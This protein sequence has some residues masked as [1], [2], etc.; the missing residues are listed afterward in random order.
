MV[1]VIQNT[2]FK[3]N[4]IG[5]NSFGIGGVNAHALL[6]KNDKD[7]DPDC[8]KL[9]SQIPRLVNV[10]GRTEDAIKHI[11]DF[12][13]KNPKRITRDFLALLGE[14]MKTQPLRGSSGFPWRGYMLMTEKG[15]K[16]DEIYEYEY[17]KTIVPAQRSE[18]IWIMFSGMGSQ[19]PSMAKSLMTIPTFAKSISRAAN[20]LKP[21]NI[22][23]YDLLLSPD[24]ELLKKNT[25]NPFVAITSMQV[26]LFDLIKELNI[27]ID[28][29]VGHSFGEV[30]CAY[31][32]GCLTLEQSVLTAYWRGKI[33]E[34][35]RLPKGMLAAV[36]LSWEEAIKKCP[37]G[38][39]AACHNGSDSV[40]ISGLYEPMVKFVEELKKENIFVRPVAGGDYPYHSPFMKAVEAKLLEQL[41]AVIKTPKPRSPKWL[42]TSWPEEDWEQPDAKYASGKYFVNNLVTPVLF[43]EAMKKAMNMKHA[44]AV[45]EVA[46]HA[47]FESIFKRCFSTLNYVGLMKRGETDNL[48]YFLQAIGKIYTLGLNPDIENLYPKVQWPVARGTQSVGSLIKWDHDRSYM[49]KKYPEFHNFATASDFVMKFAFSDFDWMFLKDHC[50]DGRCLFPATGYI[51]IVWRRMAAMKGQPWNKTPVVFENVRFH[52][53]TLLSEGSEVKFVI[54][55]LEGTGDFTVSE[56]N[57]VAATGRVFI[58]DENETLEL[59]YKLEEDDDEEDKDIPEDDRLHE[60]LENKDIY[61]ELRIRGYDYGPK[62][63][64]LV[65]ARGDGRVGKCKWTGQFIS[66]FDSMM[67]LALVA[68]PIRALFVPVGFQQ[69][70]I[71]PNLLF[72]TIRALQKEQLELARQAE[73]EA[74]RLQEEAEQKE[75]EKRKD[76]RKAIDEVDN[77][78][79]FKMGHFME[80]LRPDLDKKDAN[81]LMQESVVSTIKTGEENMAAELLGTG[82]NFREDDDEED[83]ESKQTVILPVKFDIDLR[84]IVTKGLEVKG[85]IP[86]NIPRR[87]N[88]QGLTLEQYE[89]VPHSENEAIDQRFKNELVEYISVC[90]TLMSKFLKATDKDMGSLQLNGYKL[91]DEEL[92]KQYLERPIPNE[93]HVLMNLLK[94]LIALKYDENGNII[95][96]KIDNLD[97]QIREITSKKEFDLSNDLIVTAACNERLL[98]STLDIITENGRDKS[99]R[100]MELSSKGSIAPSLIHLLKSIQ[101]GLID[102]DCVV[103]TPNPNELSDSV[104]A[105]GYRTAEWDTSNHQFLKDTNNMELIL[106]RPSAELIDSWNVQEQTELLSN[107]LKV[108]GFLILSYRCKITPPEKTLKELLPINVLNEKTVNQFITAASAQNLQLIGTKS[109]SLTSTMLVFRKVKSSFYIKKPTVIN[110]ENCKMEEWVETVKDALSDFKMDAENSPSIWLIAKDHPNGIVGMTNCLRLEPGGQGFRCIYD[111]DNKLPPVNFEKSPYKELLQLD[112]ATNVYQ[113]G[114]WGT[115]KHFRMSEQQEITQTEHAYL[116][117]ITRGD[118]SSLK[119]FEAQHKYWPMIPEKDKN[120]QEVLCHVYY[121]ALNFKDVVLVSGKI[122][123]GPESALFDCIIGLEFAGRRADTGARVMGMVPFRGIATTLLTYKDYLWEV[124]DDWT[125]EDAATV[126][127]VY[128]TAYYALITRGNLQPGESV[129]IHSGAGGVGQAAIMICQ[130]MNCDVYVTVGNAEK[131]QFIMRKFN[132]PKDHIA[133]SHD[134]TF[135]RQIMKVTKGK[136]VDVVLNSLTEDK[137]QAS[138]RCLAANGRFLEIGKYDMQMNK[139]LGL[140]AFLQNISF[141]GVGLDCI[142]RE[143][144]NSKVLRNFMV[145]MTKLMNDGIKRGVVKPIERTTFEKP[146]AEDAFRYMTLGKH[147]GKVLIKIRDEEGPGPLIVKNPTKITMSAITRTWF[148]PSKIYI[149][150]GGL[151]GFGLEFAYWLVLRGAKKIIL[152]SRIGIKNDYQQLYLKRFKQLNKFIEDYNVDISVSTHNAVEQEGA[153]DLIKEAMEKGPLGGIFNL[154]L[155]LNDGFMEN[156][157]VQTFKDVC[158]PKV[159]ASINLDK[160]TRAKCPELEYFVVFSSLTSG[161]GNQGQANYGYANSFMERLCELRRR[162]GLPGLAIEWGPIGDVG[163]V[164]E[165]LL[166]SS[167]EKTDVMK[168]FGGIMLQRLNSCLEVLDRFLQL[169]Q[170]V[171][172]SLVKADLQSSSSNTED[173]VLNQLCNHLNIDKRPNGE[174]LGDVGLDSMM[175]VE[176]QQRLERD[177]EITMSLADIKKITVGELK[178]FRDGN[179]DSIKMYALDIKRARANLAQIR[180]DIPSEP[181]SYLND[182][183][184]GKPVFFLPPVEGIF[185]TLEELALKINRPVIALNWMRAM[186]G[187][188]DIKRV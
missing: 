69:I 157:S 64:G 38:I 28:G 67:H 102:V 114:K 123:P 26:A 68:L 168:L 159:E 65:E 81:N 45:V 182:V 32:D 51:M 141:H 31:A 19:W 185:K 16:D 146:Q 187:Y 97:E 66:F 101:I 88:V 73:E 10:C 29:I 76:K 85:L 21:Y 116:N 89:F 130:S 17:K 165:Q 61:K 4:I 171:V 176:I 96:G 122:A 34:T 6:R 59:Q 57:Q 95:D 40:T 172:S 156:Q 41:N 136:G 154:A 55:I 62:F 144:P 134:V 121:S 75:M 50:V 109:D 108:K 15:T 112:L 71:D 117:V 162:D 9:A 183:R 91:A 24:S 87:P 181:I 60:I 11:F 48:D 86:V 22:D 155:V 138:V 23:L 43:N 118:F 84:A 58:P 137:L 161:R 20:C 140:F 46:P 158:D 126:P 14:V 52:R 132:I 39:V 170:P 53:P 186:Q 99:M 131:E 145:E 44:K 133:N 79:S 103:A 82:V 106:Y 128:T 169:K 180:F 167:S 188:R 94:E 98:R 1:P 124:P 184:E 150:L 152:T 49:V 166:D 113:D 74:K 35:S 18:G 47:L 25:I 70:R 135:E 54:R 77:P 90:N 173:E 153:E 100:M 80:E 37:D 179:R 72:T 78:D 175:A 139:N 178:E 92:V 148:N 110:V 151:G 107:A 27:P 147:I 125:L 30:A 160:I 7:P 143:G 8:Y 127:V 12:I 120:P 177:Y 164:A 5:L 3:D 33:V 93:K 105:P 13:E 119:W 149:I 129:L 63:Q 163:I 83:K 36:G 142:F 104:K 115:L 174:T 42:S 111:V 2:P 56:G